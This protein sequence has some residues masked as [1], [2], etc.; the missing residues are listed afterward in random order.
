ML[1]GA[2]V[3]AFTVERERWREPL[4]FAVLAGLVMAGLAW[5]AVAGGDRYADP[6]YGFAAGVL[7]T[8]LALPLFQAG[9]HRRRFRV[10]YP[11]FH[12][13]VWTDAISAGGALGFTG[14]S[15]VVLTIL[16]PAVRAAAN[17]PDPR[18]RTRGRVRLGVL[19][20]RVRRGAR[21]DPQRAPPA[22]HLAHGRRSGAVAAR[23]AA[24]RSALV[25]FLAVDGGLGP[26]SA[27][28]R[29]S[30]RDADPA[31]A[32]PRAR[33]CS[34]TPSLRQDD[35]EMPANRAMRLA[36]LVLAL[37]ILPL[38][39]FAAVSMGTRIAQHGL[40]PERLWAVIAIG[41]ACAYAIAYAVA[42]LGG[43]SGRAAGA[44]ACAAPTSRSRPACA[45][46]RC[47]SRCRSSIS[48]RSRRAARSRACKSGKVSP[49]HFDFTALRWD[50]G[51]GGRRALARLAKSGNATVA[52][53]ARTALA[54]K[55]RT[56]ATLDRTNRTRAD[57]QLRVQPD[58]PE[59]RE[60]V[61][62]YLVTQPYEC[63]DRC[64]ALDLGK[65]A[66][67]ARRIAI[68]QGSTYSVIAFGPGA[69]P[70]RPWQPA[71]APTL[72]PNSKVELDDGPVIRIDGKPIGV[73]ID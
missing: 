15:W 57:F 1:F 35:E 31:R 37:M 3:A 13:L 36:A 46:W 42:V 69:A 22:R 10:P 45:A 63:Q 67:G 9:F 54:Q 40:S 58:D 24:W 61:L 14:L 39:G 27:V 48:A 50:M 49:E 38:S 70:V 25:V 32:A 26:A 12:D 60:R 55:E 73:P 71:P 66:D 29:D 17:P 4:A 53:L 41:V 68:V 23:G 16:R 6:G 33:S 62:D 21:H 28:A 44:S 52:E 18:P 19:R 56:Y 7:A 11:E 5:R 59:V 2:L 64:V 72:G 34:P 8:A 30:Q 65:T 20:R 51:E 47:S 43:L